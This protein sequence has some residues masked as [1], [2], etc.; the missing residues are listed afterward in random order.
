M[1]HWFLDMN[2][3]KVLLPPKKMEFWPKIGNFGHFEPNIGLFGHLVL[4]PTKNNENEVPRWLFDKWKS[5]LLLLL[6]PKK[7]RIFGSKPAKF[8][9]KYAF[10]VILGQILAILAHLDQKTMLRWF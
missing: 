6:P 7:I 10:L 8:G 2:V 4:C 9:P 3:P 5:K 1:S